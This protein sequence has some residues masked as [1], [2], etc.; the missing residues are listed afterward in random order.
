ML[1]NNLVPPQLSR[2]CLV[3]ATAGL[4]CGCAASRALDEPAHK[5]LDVLK[6]GTNRDLVR[7][8]LGQPLPSVSGSDC[9]VYSFPEGSSGWKY[10]RAMG[11]SLLDIG[12]LGLSEVVA[13]PVEAGVGKDKVQ[14]RVCFDSKQSVT[15]AERLQVGVPPQL[16]TGAYPPVPPA[17]P[18]TASELAPA[19][20]TGAPTDASAA[21]AMKPDAQPAAQTPASTSSIPAPPPPTTAGSSATSP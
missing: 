13:N 7:A 6:P 5:N 10:M 9:D 20:G 15:Y 14:L 21:S 1:I 12:T 18:V 16:V 19:A 3:A 11:Y 4:L 8:E 17:P 2:I